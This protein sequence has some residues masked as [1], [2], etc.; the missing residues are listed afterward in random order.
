MLNDFHIVFMPL[1]LSICP[2]H[3]TFASC[4]CTRETVKTF[5]CFVKSNNT[6]DDFGPTG[7]KRAFFFL[8]TGISFIHNIW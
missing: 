5:A 4:Q 1:Y 6:H 3:N 8:K 7:P 2:T